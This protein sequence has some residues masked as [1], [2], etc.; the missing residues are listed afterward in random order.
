MNVLELNTGGDGY[1]VN[2]TSQTNGS[3][4]S[5][6]GSLEAH[7][8]AEKILLS[9]YVGK[10][11][12]SESAK[13]SCKEPEEPCCSANRKRK[14]RDSDECCSNNAKRTKQDSEEENSLSAEETL[15]V[16]G[17]LCSSDNKRNRRDSEGEEPDSQCSI[18]RIKHNSDE[19]SNLPE[20]DE[21]T[22]K[23]QNLTQ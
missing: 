23:F 19:T 4:S 13:E 12:S 1:F 5:G 22:M 15:Q 2:F 6:K 18:K 7:S 20:F 10:S 11:L 8:N 3:L 17:D 9:E 14:R 21:I 16:S